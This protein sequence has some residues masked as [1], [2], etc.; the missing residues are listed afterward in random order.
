MIGGLE[1]G[2]CEN[3]CSSKYRV[4]LQREANTPEGKLEMKRLQK[5]DEDFAKRMDR[6]QHIADGQEK[7][8][9]AAYEQ[10]QDDELRLLRDWYKR[11]GVSMDSIKLWHS[12]PGFK[13]GDFAIVAT[14]VPVRWHFPRVSIGAAEPYENALDASKTKLNTGRYPIADVVVV[15]TKV[16]I[17][18]FGEDGAVGIEEIGGDS[19][20][21]SGQVAVGALRKSAN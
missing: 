16:R 10:M 7:Q 21:L 6:N 13:T 9:H 8:K 19:P 1:L 2:S 15:G 17:T 5:E 18:D 20:G 12:S 3:K 14:R 4:C 11:Y